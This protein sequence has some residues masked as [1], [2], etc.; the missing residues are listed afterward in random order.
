MLLGGD[1]CGRTQ[2]GNNNA[3]CQDTEISWYEW[4]QSTESDE[5]RAFTR[6]L[7][8][9]RHE[10]RVFSRESF[11]RGQELKGSGLP[12][13]WWFRADGLK[14]TRRNWQ[15]GEHVL[16]MFLNGRE[17]TTPGPF[18]ED[19]VDDSFLVLFNGHY[20]DRSFILPRRRFGAQWALELS[21]ADPSAEAGSARYA[22]RTE[23]PV[24]ARSI[25]VLKRVR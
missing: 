6:R 5:L 18:G 11:L 7:I 14:M 17:I 19:V 10:H 23:V 21:T 1:E 15:D 25:V 9:L 20:E 2:Y 24:M 8:R 16:G 3:W 13:I 22:P 12:D 4:T